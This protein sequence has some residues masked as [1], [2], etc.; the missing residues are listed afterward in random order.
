MNALDH[1]MTELIIAQLRSWK[2]KPASQP[3]V[4][5]FS[6]AGDLAFCAGGD[7]HYLYEWM[8]AG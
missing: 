1:E 4:I 6:G 2:N 8:K 3:K 7:L 5:I